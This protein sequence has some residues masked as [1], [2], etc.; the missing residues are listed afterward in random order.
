MRD[1]LSDVA[2]PGAMAFR[3]QI[4]SARAGFFARAHGRPDVVP[5][6]IPGARGKS[7]R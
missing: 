6:R 1:V 2:S 5:G 3:T 7:L 4:F